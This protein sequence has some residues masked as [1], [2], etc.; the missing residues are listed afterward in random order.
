MPTV[1]SPDLGV[2]AEQIA[3]SVPWERIQP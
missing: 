3:A 1:A 2:P